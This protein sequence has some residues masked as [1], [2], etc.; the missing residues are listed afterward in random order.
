[1]RR[2]PGEVDPQRDEQRNDCLVLKIHRFAIGARAG[3]YGDQDRRF[4][5]GLELI[6]AEKAERLEELGTSPPELV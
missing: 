3:I 4:A 2:M 5:A 1:M 6:G